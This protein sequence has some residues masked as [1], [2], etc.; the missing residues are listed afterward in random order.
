VTKKVLCIV[1]IIWLIK[2]DS[3]TIV[4]ANN[5]NAPL[6]INKIT[7]RQLSA[8]AVAKLEP[9]KT[10]YAYFGDSTIEVP[11]YDLVYFQDKITK[12]PE[13]IATGPVIDKALKTKD[14]YNG[15]RDKYIVWIGLAIIS[16]ILIYLTS[17]MMKKIGGE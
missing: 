16:I 3:F 14:E 13:I 7:A 15:A 5:D 10:Y 4:I 2:S 8:Y 17:N 6:K 12:D 1:A 9:S 11:Q